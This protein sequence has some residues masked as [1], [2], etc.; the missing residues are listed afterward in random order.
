MDYSTKKSVKSRLPWVKTRLNLKM[1]SFARRDQLA[2]L[3]NYV[4]TDVYKKIWP[5]L[6]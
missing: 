1:G 6:I 5:K 4:L 3:L 2:P